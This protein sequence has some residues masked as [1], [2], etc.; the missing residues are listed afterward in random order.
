MRAGRGLLIGSVAVGLAG[1]AGCTG[2]S[3][4]GGQTPLT[5]ATTRPTGYASAAAPGSQPMR[6]SA[7]AAAIRFYDLYSDGQFAATWK[8]LTPQ[9]R[10]DIPERVWVG[11]HEGCSAGGA[12]KPMTVTAVTVFGNAAIVTESIAGSV[13]EQVFSEVKG[14]W[15]YG[16]GTLG[17]YHRG[18]VTADISTARAAG[19]CGGSKTF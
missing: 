13:S 17:I 15:D 4:S 8:L 9:M 12:A 1:L 16:P 6:T 19:F 7:R 14:N 11:V 10:R 3:A 5:A 2:G 18:S